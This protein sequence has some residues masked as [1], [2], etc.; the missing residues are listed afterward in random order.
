MAYDNIHT[1]LSCP[2]WLGPSPLWPIQCIL[3][4]VDQ[5]L[6]WWLGKEGVKTTENQILYIRVQ[7]FWLFLTFWGIATHPWHPKG[8]RIWKLAKK[9]FNFIHGLRKFLAKTGKCVF[10]V[11]FQSLILEAPFDRSLPFFQ[12][13]LFMG[14]L[15]HIPN[16]LSQ[17]L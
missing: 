6:P 10:L 9:I 5:I 14:S 2:A 11:W 16:F 17:K 13:V 1:V 15:I 12:H 7:W 4:S 8:P 3:W